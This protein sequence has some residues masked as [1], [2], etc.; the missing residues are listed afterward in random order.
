MSDEIFRQLENRSPEFLQKK[1]RRISEVYQLLRVFQTKFRVLQCVLA[2]N[3]FLLTVKFLINLVDLRINFI[4]K[5]YT[6]HSD[7]KLLLDSLENEKKFFEGNVESWPKRRQIERKHYLFFEG[8]KFVLEDL[9]PESRKRYS[10]EIFDVN[11]YETTHQEV[12]RHFNTTDEVEIDFLCADKF[13]SRLIYRELNK[14]LIEIENCLSF[15][16]VDD[17]FEAAC[18]DD[19]IRVLLRIIIGVKELRSECVEEY[20]EKKDSE[21]IK[22]VLSDEIL[23]IRENLNNFDE[24][25]ELDRNRIV[26]ETFVVNLGN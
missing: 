12:L 8:E 23:S 21:I 14:T 18:F 24:L 11:S 4:K 22:S 10:I 3:F 13:Q 2:D 1:Y 19:M 15:F 9:H 5:L 16:P 25:R 7:R 26:A 6:L 20:C 17:F